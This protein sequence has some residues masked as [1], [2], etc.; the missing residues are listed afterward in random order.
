M[1]PLLGWISRKAY[2]LE[3]RMTACYLPA[4]PEAHVFATLISLD[5]APLAPDHEFSRVYDDARRGRLAWLAGDRRHEL[6][7]RRGAHQHL[8]IDYATV[9]PDG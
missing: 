1:E 8:E 6:R 7:F 3:P 9:E 2:T 4:E 5:D